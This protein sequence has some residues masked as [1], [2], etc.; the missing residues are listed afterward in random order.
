MKQQLIIAGLPSSGKSRLSGAI[1][2]LLTS[3]GLPTAASLKKFEKLGKFCQEEKTLDLITAYE[4]QIA[5][6]KGALDEDELCAMYENF[7]RAARYFRRSIFHATI[8]I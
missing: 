6:G 4:L 5:V 1:Q 3:K 8:A 2:L 7:N